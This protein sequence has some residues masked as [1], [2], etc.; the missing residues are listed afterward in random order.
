[1]TE[2][3]ISSLSVSTHVPFCQ[4]CFGPHDTE[5][6]LQP[7]ASDLPTLGDSCSGVPNGARAMLL[8][9]GP[10]GSRSGRFWPHMAELRGHR[11]R[12]DAHP[13][14]KRTTDSMQYS[15]VIASVA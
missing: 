13:K 8:R 15:S 10:V 9:S 7:V 11:A 6:A 14:R 1:V 12:A 2:S 5:P 3:T 4:R